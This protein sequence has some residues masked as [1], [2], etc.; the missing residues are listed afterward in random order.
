MLRVA[1]GRARPNTEWSG[2]ISRLEFS[3]NPGGGLGANATANDRLRSH[4][5]SGTS[6]V[7]TVPRSRAEHEVDIEAG[8]GA[9]DERSACEKDN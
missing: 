8:D 2:K 4:S 5:T 9:S 3:S 7:L 1:L 6:T